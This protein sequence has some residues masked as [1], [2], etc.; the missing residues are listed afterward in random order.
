MKRKEL[1]IAIDGPAASGKSTTARNVARRLGY[2][3]ID[4]GAM[5]RAFTLKVLREGIDPSDTARIVQIVD[6][7]HVELRGKG[8][9]LSVLLDGEDV[10]SEIRREDV[11]HAVS[12]VSSIRAVRAAMVREQQRL[13]RGGGVVLE[14]RDIGTVVF[15]DADL[16]IFMVAS[17]E[18]R[19]TRRQR[20]L[21][22]QGVG[23]SHERL[24]R[25]I[26]ERDKKDS[27]RAESPLSRAEGAIELDTSGL[28]IEE[29]VQR[30]VDEAARVLKG[31]ERV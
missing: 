30:V 5:Y 14:G 13:G 7:S 12:E 15:P 18:E 6:T 24:V 17:I 22:E 3:H 8:S 21:R 2:L 9:T 26:R 19:A 20:E 27:T 1:I 23:V 4:T 25:E 10:T 28:S 29:Q 16:K 31:R 11:T